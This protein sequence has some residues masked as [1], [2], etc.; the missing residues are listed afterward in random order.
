MKNKT[1]RDK[2]FHIYCYN[3]SF[4]EWF[5][6]QAALSCKSNIS[7]RLENDKP[8]CHASNWQQYLCG[9]TVSFEHFIIDNTLHIPQNTE[10]NFY[11]IWFWFGGNFVLFCRV[12]NNCH[13]CWIRWHNAE[14]VLQQWQAKDNF[15]IKV[16]SNQMMGEPATKFRHFL[17]F[18]KAIYSKNVDWIELFYVCFEFCSTTYKSSILTKP[19]HLN[20]GE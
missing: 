14:K 20:R 3:Q 10:H 2:T 13:F 9:L 18:S 16:R 6:Q 7:L 15:L 11:R 4:P 12:C 8:L 19:N 5:G 1:G 17:K